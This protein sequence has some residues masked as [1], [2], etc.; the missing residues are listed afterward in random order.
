MGGLLLGRLCMCR[1]EERECRF[2]GLKCFAIYLQ[3]VCSP[4]ILSVDAKDAKDGFSLAADAPKLVPHSFRSIT[5]LS[6][7][8]S[9]GRNN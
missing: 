5:S 1:F 9:I 4:V 7:F 2:T 8:E 3:E 6:Q